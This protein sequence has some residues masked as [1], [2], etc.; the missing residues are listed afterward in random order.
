MK[1]RKETNETFKQDNI[2]SAGGGDYRVRHG[3]NGRRGGRYNR[4]FKRR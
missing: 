1:R 3:D 4:R 2:G